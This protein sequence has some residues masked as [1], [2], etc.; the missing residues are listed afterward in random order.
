MGRIKKEAVLESFR[1]WLLEQYSDV[2]L[3]QHRQGVVGVPWD[4]EKL[5]DVVVKRVR[6]VLKEADEILNRAW[7]LQVNPERCG[8][9]EFGE[10]RVGALRELLCKLA[11]E[12]ETLDQTY[13][14]KKNA[15]PLVAAMKLHDYV[16]RLID[17]AL[18]EEERSAQTKVEEATPPAERVGDAAEDRSEAP[19]PA[20]PSP[21]KKPRQIGRIAPTAKRPASAWRFPFWA[22]TDADLSLGELVVAEGQGATGAPVKLIG[23]IED[24]WRESSFDSPMQH[25]AAHDL[26]VASAEVATEPLY[27][28]VGEVAVLYR[29]D[30]RSTP[31]GGAWPVRAAQARE[32]EEAINKDVD[33][34]MA[35]PAGVVPLRDEVAVANYDLR[36]LAG[37]EG[38][39]VNVSGIS[40]VAAK[41]SYAVFLLTG[42]LAQARRPGTGGLAAML[43]NVKEEDL[44]G[45][46]V[47]PEVWKRVVSGNWHGVAGESVKVYRTLRERNRDFDPGRLFGL[48]KDPVETDDP[49]VVYLAPQHP[50][51]DVPKPF[52]AVDESR[53]AEVLPFQFDLQEIGNR[54]VAAFDPEDLDEKME[55]TLHYFLEQSK[56]D[57]LQTLR[58]FRDLVKKELDR[59]QKKK[60]DRSGKGGGR[61]SDAGH[62]LTILKLLHRLRGVERDLRGLVAVEGKQAEPPDLKRLLRSG[63]VLVFDVTQISERARRVLIGWLIDETENLL[64]T[65]KSKVG[66]LDAPPPPDLPVPGR[67]VMFADELNRFA[68]KVGRSEVG[69]IL[70]RVAA[71]GRSYGLAIVGMQQQASKVNEQILTNSSTLVVGRSHAAELGRGDAYGWMSRGLKTQAAELDKGQVIA[72]HP[73]WRQPLILRFPL[74]HHRLVEQLSEELE[75]A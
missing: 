22:E 27:P 5:P 63:R 30:G 42:L 9:D 31:P 13:K 32:A 29:S 34:R 46:H 40:G 24:L 3:P 60:N 56:R 11:V 28:L 70:G 25:F 23:A 16:E 38:G 66:S 18:E 53:Y 45:I 69:R 72:S 65:R 54:L 64:T 71:Q 7:K 48:V 57:G 19:K 6:S 12:V 39:H 43:F 73:A 37:P 4:E 59:I 51:A 17:E 61:S 74:P 21:R 1:A 36:F 55:V 15:A 47:D 14:R 26:G 52:T 8:L 41:T 44:M 68:P 33:D 75:D 49:G 10:G 35:V 20:E 67:V 58:E 62:E 50:E 2:L